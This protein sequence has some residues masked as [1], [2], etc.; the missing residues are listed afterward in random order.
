VVVR[1]RIQ[2]VG[3]IPIRSTRKGPAKLPLS[4][5]TAARLNP[6]RQIVGTVLERSAERR[7]RLDT[8]AARIRSGDDDPRRTQ[9]FGDTGSSGVAVVLAARRLRTGRVAG[10]VF[11]ADPPTPFN[12]LRVTRRAY[13]VWREAGL[14]PIGLHEA[15][16]TFASLMIAAGVN[17]K[18]LCTYMGRSSIAITLDRYGHLFPGNEAEAATLLGD[19]LSRAVEGNA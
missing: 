9:A 10:L 5:L 15:R 7:A 12:Y 18:A 17:A 16:H 19:Y 2:R 3:S 6:R 14:E 11:D 13:R 1:S 4:P 8:V